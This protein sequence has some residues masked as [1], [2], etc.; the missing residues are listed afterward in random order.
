DITKFRPCSRVPLEPD[1]AAAANEH[2]AA[3]IN[4]IKQIEEALAA[5]VGQRFT[6]RA[7]GQLFAPDQL[8]VGFV[9]QLD[10]VVGTA[11]Y[12]HETG[13]LVKQL[14]QP[15]SLSKPVAFG[16]HLS[17]SLGAGTE[18]ACHCAGFIAHWRVGESKPG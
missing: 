3:A 5:E 18:H 13:R 9:D 2:L 1:R 7:A 12:R 15:F 16:Q 11:H 4:V 14:S 6:H 8:P 17:S 10:N